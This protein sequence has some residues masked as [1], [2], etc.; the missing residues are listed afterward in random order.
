MTRAGNPTVTSGVPATK[1][2]QTNWPRGM[3]ARAVTATRLYNLAL[4]KPALAG[5]WRVNDD[6]SAAGVND[7]NGDEDDES[8]DVF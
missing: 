4:I 7:D 5:N 3:P 2:F 8:D 6:A 1:R